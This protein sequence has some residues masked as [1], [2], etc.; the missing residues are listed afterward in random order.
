[1]CAQTGHCSMSVCT[2]G[3]LQH[4]CVLKLYIAAQVCAKMVYCS[5]IMCS[6]CIL[7]HKCVLKWYITA[8]VCAQMEYCI[9]TPVLPWNLNHV[10]I[11]VKSLPLLPSLVAP[12]LSQNGYA[13]NFIN[14]HVFTLSVNHIILRGVVAGWLIFS[15]LD[16]E[17]FCHVYNIKYVLITLAF[18]SVCN[19]V[20][21]CGDNIA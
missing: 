13:V 3:T 21:I 15:Q 19:C 7:Q 20:Y 11:T 18:L 14:R 9:C 17:I 1:M 5:T 4:E 16:E 6:N 8:R 12:L 2:N 10:C